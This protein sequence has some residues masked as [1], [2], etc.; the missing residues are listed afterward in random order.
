MPWTS[1]TSSAGRATSAPTPP[2]LLQ[3][4][5]PAAAIS[6]VRGTG[7]HRVVAAAILRG[8]EHKGSSTD[9]LAFLRSLKEESELA[10][11][12]G[13]GPVADSMTEMLWPEVLKMQ[14]ATAA[15]T[16]EVMT[17]F[18][19]ATE[20]S[21]GGLDKF[22]GGLEGA[23]PPRSRCAA[24]PPRSPA[25]LPPAPRARAR[26]AAIACVR[27]SARCHSSDVRAG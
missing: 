20:L 13:N 3:V 23:L 17:K 21:F 26:T 12:F 10:A 18:A 5:T 14:A 4:S 22:F 24:L 8:A 25:A 19:G 6:Q 1:G 9:A 15:T 27:E 16:D 7:V 2:P 11:L